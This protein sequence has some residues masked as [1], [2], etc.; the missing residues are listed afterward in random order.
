MTEPRTFPRFGILGEPRGKSL[1]ESVDALLTGPW[2]VASKPD[3]NDDPLYIGPR[4]ISSLHARNALL[5]SVLFHVIVVMC[6]VLRPVPIAIVEPTIQE[7]ANYQL[8][9]YPMR[10]LPRLSPSR[11]RNSGAIHAAD[12]TR[13]SQRGADAHHPRQTILSQPVI[14]THPRQTLVV[15]HAPLAAPKILPPLPNVVQWSEGI[16]SS[17]PAR[18]SLSSQVSHQAPMLPNRRNQNLS[19]P[20][21]RPTDNASGTLLFADATPVVPRPRLQVAPG[22][23]RPVAPTPRDRGQQALVPQIDAANAG[24]SASQNWI[25][26]SADPAPVPPP[27]TP[28]QGNL[29]AKLS[30]SPDGLRPGDPAGGRVGGTANGGAGDGSRSGSSG[31]SGGTGD[32]PAGISISGGGSS[33]P[34]SGSGSGVGHSGYGSPVPLPETSAKSSLHVLPGS[35][36]VRHASSRSATPSPNSAPSPSLPSGVIDPEHVLRT[37]QFYTLFVNMPNLTSDAGSWVLDF[38]E[39]DADGNPSHKGGGLSGPVPLHKVD[40]KYPPDLVN[41]NVQGE[42]ILYAI[43][44]ADGSVDSVQLIRGVDPDL[45]RN[46]MEAFSRWRFRPGSRNN[47][48]VELEALVRIPFRSTPPL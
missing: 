1:R 24:G 39:L 2:A 32:G 41:G 23:S 43:I 10:D 34:V 45:D 4:W 21:I 17:Q 44:R 31:I 14:P 7:S 29:Y 26:L 36:A 30:I 16:Q 19:S 27:T 11:R 28:P 9:W 12:A 37:K 8:T 5:A 38:A 35:L 18:P 13:V 46:A 22:G 3:S 40:P 47:L 20:E 15:S 48:P 6:I 25:A 42:V 33:N